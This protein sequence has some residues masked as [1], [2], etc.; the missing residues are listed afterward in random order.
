MV[1]NICAASYHVPAELIQS[2]TIRREL[3]SIYSNLVLPLES[4]VGLG[5][6]QIQ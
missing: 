1:I 3:L 4:Y 5:S 6:Q 2:T